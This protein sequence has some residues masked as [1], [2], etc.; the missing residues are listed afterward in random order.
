MV[1]HAT[2]QQALEEFLSLWQGRDF[3]AMGRFLPY[4]GTPL[5]RQKVA[6]IRAQFAAKEISQ[7]Q[8]VAYK[9]TDPAATN[10]DVDL[11]YRQNDEWEYERWRFRMVHLD[12]LSRPVSRTQDGRWTAYK[13]WVLSQ[14]LRSLRA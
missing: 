5:K 11:L 9:D 13:S 7:Y 3:R 8:I 1:M 4:Q 10:V 2:P 6:E 14:S 12:Q